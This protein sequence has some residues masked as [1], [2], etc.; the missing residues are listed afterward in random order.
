MKLSNSE[1]VRAVIDV[2]YDGFCCKCTALCNC[3]ATTLGN[4]PV[5]P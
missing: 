1:N 3:T 5:F 2:S 4:F